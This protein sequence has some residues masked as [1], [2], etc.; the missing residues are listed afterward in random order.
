MTTMT[1]THRRTDELTVREKS[2]QWGEYVEVVGGTMRQTFAIINGAVLT[3]E[4]TDDDVTNAIENAGY[5]TAP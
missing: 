3:H 4:D 1:A 2:N 5:E